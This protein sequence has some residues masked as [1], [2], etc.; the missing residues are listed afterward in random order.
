MHEVL[1]ERRMSVNTE[2]MI[3]VYGSDYL[4]YFQVQEGVFVS[5]SIF[6]SDLRELQAIHRRYTA[7][8]V[9]VVSFESWEHELAGLYIREEQVSRNADDR[10][11]TISV[12]VYGE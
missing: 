8:Y 6:K 7:G 9:K 1:A 12:P 5:L 2:G 4:H 3:L 11:G 10:V